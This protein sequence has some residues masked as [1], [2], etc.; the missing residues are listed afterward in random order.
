MPDPSPIDAVVFDM[1][2]VLIDSE[3]FWLEAETEVFG[4]LGFALTPVMFARTMGMRIVDVVRHWLAHGLETE[5][6]PQ[7]VADRLVQEMA[8]IVRARGVAAD[9]ALEALA[10]VER[11]GLRPAIASSSPARLIDAT[12]E[13]CG[14]DG[15]FEVVHS[16]EREPRGKPDPAVF[17]TA[18]S[19]LGVPA[20]RCLAIE[21]SPAGVRAAKA[22]GMACVVVPATGAEDAVRDAG[23]DVVL[24][25]LAALDD[26]IWDAAGVAP[27]PG[28]VGLRGVVEADL[29]TLFEHQREP[30]ANRMAAFPA[31]DRDAFMA[32]W[33]ANVLADPTT[34]ARAIVVD[35]QVVGNVVAWGGEDQRDVGYW[36]DREHWGRGIA[37]KAL[38]AFLRLE[39][40]RPLLAHVATHNAGSI[41]V[42]EKCGFEV[43]ETARVVDEPGSPEI[44]EH[45]MRLEGRASDAR[46]G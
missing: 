9:G 40:T 41:R 14:L 37:T 34:I 16:A 22:A 15:R 21:D 45:V 25:S 19:L 18:A 4:A 1:D 27:A 42:L 31:R 11:H 43:V 32:H 17:L 39:R 8:G 23:A 46:E 33:T 12:L 3:P 44:E 20:G 24:P 13:T 26:G 10:F 5:R 36:I 2:G 38:T 29:P 6:S 28:A 7:E 30:E 35:G